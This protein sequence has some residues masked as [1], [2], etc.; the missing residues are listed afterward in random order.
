MRL[1]GKGNG[2]SFLPAG[3]PRAWDFWTIMTSGSQTWR[4]LA[5]VKLFISLR[6]GI[7]AGSKPVVGAG[8]KVKKGDLI[9]V[10]PENALGSNIHASI[11]GTVL[12]VNEAV[13]IGG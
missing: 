10:K 12:D 7:G 9:A 5:R 4:R 2:A 8:D 1:P 13:V 3:W 6:Q 11:D